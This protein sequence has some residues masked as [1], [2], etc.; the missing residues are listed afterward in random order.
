MQKISQI[1]QSQNQFAMG[2][3]GLGSLM[4]DSGEGANMTQN[5]EMGEGGESPT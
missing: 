2:M 3:P 4:N 5:Y 1:T